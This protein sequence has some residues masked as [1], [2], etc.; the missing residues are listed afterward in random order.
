MRV[1]TMQKIT[2]ARIQTRIQKLMEERNKFIEK[3]N[4]WEANKLGEQI[5]SL[6]SQLEAQNTAK[7]ES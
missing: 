6:R 5:R 2:S 1:K 3:H 4:D 7:G